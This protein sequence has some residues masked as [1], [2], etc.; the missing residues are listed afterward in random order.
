VELTDYGNDGHSSSIFSRRG[1]KYRQGKTFKVPM[2]DLGEFLK[3]QSKVGLLKMNCEGAEVE[4]LLRCPDEQLQKCDQIC[5]AF[6]LGKEKG[7][8]FNQQ[9]LDAIIARMKE[10]GYTALKTCDRGPYYLFYKA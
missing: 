3:T 2:I 8:G 7:M 5:A 6:H 4:M 9:Q 10:L 1:K